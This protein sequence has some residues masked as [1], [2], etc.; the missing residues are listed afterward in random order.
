MKVWMMGMGL[1]LLGIV[2][3]MAEKTGELDHERVLGVWHILAVATDCQEF[4]THKDAM[5]IVA[6]T[7]TKTEQGD[8]KLAFN[9]PM[10][11]GCKK[12]EMVF[13]KGEDGKL[14]HEGAW[15]SKTVD[16]LKTDYDNF[17]IATYL[18]KKNGKSQGSKMVVLYGAVRQDGN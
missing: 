7:V 3:V 5:K 1:A 8:L 18:V 4:W 13:T 12:I 2:H 11:Q 6:T 16:E 15:G 9:F 17:G 10:P 14:V